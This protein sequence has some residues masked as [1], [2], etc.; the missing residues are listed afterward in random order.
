M[1]YMFRAVSPP[2]IR[3]SKFKTV[4]TASGMY[5]V[6]NFELLMM[7]GVTARN[8]QSIDRNK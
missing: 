2:T 1:L 7:G 5:T 4:H 6:L 3:S 8:M